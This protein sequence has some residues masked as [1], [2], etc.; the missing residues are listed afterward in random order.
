MSNALPA[1][2]PPTPEE[3][4]RITLEVLLILCASGTEISREAVS[5]ALA[6]R[7]HL[8]SFISQLL[9]QEKS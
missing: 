6:T 3:L 1:I 9:S 4:H 8:R 5:Y 7:V 2:P